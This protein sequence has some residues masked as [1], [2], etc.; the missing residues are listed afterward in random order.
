MKYEIF[1]SHISDI[2]DINY[3]DELLKFSRRTYKEARTLKNK[4]NNDG[5]NIRDL[6]YAL[7]Q[8][9]ISSEKLSDINN[10]IKNDKTSY[11]SDIM[12]D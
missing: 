10:I 12:N 5:I 9:I 3:N 2:S 4:I 6:T 8:K 1:T 7:R 11:W